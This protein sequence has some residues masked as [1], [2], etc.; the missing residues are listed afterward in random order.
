LS[1]PSWE[2]WERISCPTLIVR[3]GD[4]LV[5]ADVARKMVERLPSARL[6]ELPDASHDLHLDR[7]DAWRQTLGSFVDSERACML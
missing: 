6:V 3:A 5:E 2:A 4:G 1:A 7:P